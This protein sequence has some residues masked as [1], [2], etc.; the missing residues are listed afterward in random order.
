MHENTTHDRQTG[1]SLIEVLVTMV[2]LSVGLLGIAG[3]QASGMRNNHA[4]YTKTQ[5]TN[6]AMDMA[7]RIRA[8]PLGQ[9]DYVGFDSDSEQAL[10]NPDCIAAGCT[11][12]QLADYDQFEWSQPF[13]ANTK[14]ILPAGQGLIT[15]EVDGRLTITILWREV[16]YDG[17]AFNDCGI[18]DLAADM[19]CLQLSFQP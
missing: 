7:E 11:P 19:T 6:L 3:M 1:F 9:A 12:A 15:Q 17:M 2:V 18:D 8:N 5:A 13:N 14:P 10:A 4:A 16:A